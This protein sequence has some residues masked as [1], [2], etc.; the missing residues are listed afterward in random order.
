MTFLNKIKDKLNSSKNSKDIL[1]LL[2]TQILLKPIQFL[3]SFIVA[4]YLG[5]EHYGILKSVEL[6]QM[7]NKFGNL[8][9]KSALVREAAT[10]KA[11]GENENVQ[12][13][14][15][16]AYTGEFV[17]SFI[18]FVAG[19][20]S[21]I[22]FESEI[23]SNAIVLAS[24][25]LFCMKLFGLIQTELQLLEDFKYMSKTIL[26]TG[27]L[28]SI[29]VVLTVP[30]FNIYAVLGVPILSTLF[31]TFLAFK[32]IGYFFKFKV[33]KLVFKNLLKVS[34]PLTFGSLSYGLF[35]Y[36]ERILILSFLGLTAVGYFGFAETI[37]SILISLL[38]SSVI[39]VR[40]MKIYNELGH[41]NYS[42]VHQIVKKES[43]ILVSTS[44]AIII[45]T[46]FSLNM[47][48]P[49]FLPKWIDAIPVTILFLFT[50]PLRLVSS[51][52]AIVVKAPAINKLIF[53][54]IMY[55]IKSLIIIIGMLT[56]NYYDNLSLSNF[57][58][59]DLAAYTIIHLTY[60]IYYNKHYVQ[61]FLK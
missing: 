2:L 29:F 15:N 10:S 25:S 41:E 52:V 34:I 3:K 30:F 43:T 50:V 5:P 11:I 51:Y 59:I 12:A 31:I 24:I 23:I 27:V 47:L 46:V 40:K 38:L 9:F 19:L 6:I 53:E 36:T 17:L 58:Y 18:L 7:L 48:I 35:R 32:K 45:F 37:A 16:N 28:N 4:K 21:S 20:L 44:L 13:L 22:Y 39:K 54:P 56:L 8:G 61:R 14:K 33:N 49:V 57:L 60:L 55:L 1:Y 26:L 42:A